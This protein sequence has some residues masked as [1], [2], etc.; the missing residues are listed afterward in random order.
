MYMYQCIPHH[1]DSLSTGGAVYHG[2]AFTLDVVSNLISGGHWL[3]LV[4]I[5]TNTVWNWTNMQISQI[6]KKHTRNI[7]D[8][9]EKLEIAIS[10]FYVRT[11]VRNKSKKGEKSCTRSATSGRTVWIPSSAKSSG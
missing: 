7:K 1:Y 5:D 4:F 10:S 11:Y 8:I 6:A 2:R 3:V 9:N